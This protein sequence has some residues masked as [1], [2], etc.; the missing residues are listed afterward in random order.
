MKRFTI[1]NRTYFSGLLLGMLCLAGCKKS[2]LERP[3]TDAIVD[4]NFYKTDEQLLAASSLLYNK[5]WFDYNENPAFSF[6]DIRAGTAFRGY[7]ERGNVEFNT[8]DITPENRRAWSSLFVVIGQ[9]NLLIANVGRYAG[10]GVSEQAKRTAIA[11]ARF[12]RAAAY[13]MLV[14]NWGEV[15]IIENNLDLLND[16]TVKKHTVKSIWRFLTR[17]M[18]AVAEA[19]PAETVPG[20]VS[21]WSAEGMLARFYLTRAGVEANGGSRNQSYLDSA[22]YYA[23]RVITQSGKKL[24]PNYGDLFK[25]PY[26]NNQESL[27]ELQW[28]FLPGGPG[29]GLGNGAISHFN[30]SNE[31]SAEGWGG[32]KAATW[33]MLSQYEGITASG[34]TMLSGRT[35]DRRLKETFMFPGFVYPEITR[36]VGGVDTKPYIVQYTND[37]ER[38]FANIK[39]YVVGQGKDIG[40][41]TIEPQR[42]PHNT[43]MLRLAE[44]YLVYI[45]ATLGNGAT[46]V[47]PQA[48]QYLNALRNR[49]GMPNYTDQNGAPLPI[50][51]D[52]ILSERFK[53]FAI[54]GMAWYDLVSLHYWN[55]QKA[56]DILNSQDRGFYWIEPDVR[57]AQAN[58]WVIKKT[59]WANPP[60][61]PRKINAHAGNFR[62]PIPSVE[63]AQAPWLNEAAVDYP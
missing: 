3:P 58:N 10:S 2:F 45:E 14:M 19:L 44:M 50:T 18:R 35:L 32:D 1:K 22:K 40:I 21:S 4:A 31:I 52:L 39:K 49:A 6:G 29:Y 37:A 42:Y 36:T 63:T 55:P 62:I 41:P 34:D 27:F 48:V 59:P 53:E 9:S 13:R 25:Y 46:T 38:N 30:P 33:W 11:E 8:T 20:R 60:A 43:Y 5:V 57:N 12:M 56:Y 23:H 61:N 7:N 54:E 51:L 15:P 28:T 17:E 16:P 26:D 24:M 47:D